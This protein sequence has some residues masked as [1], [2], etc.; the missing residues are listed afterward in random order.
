MPA[1]VAA[2]APTA[3]AEATAPTTAELA[4]DQAPTGWGGPRLA[5]IVPAP[6]E[7]A[8]PPASILHRPA[9]AAAAL[10]LAVAALTFRRVRS[11]RPA[12]LPT[13]A[14]GLALQAA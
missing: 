13:A 6:L 14:R 5:T 4:G 11:L 12:H 10:W 7:V 1:P 2:P 9:L 3:V 8:A